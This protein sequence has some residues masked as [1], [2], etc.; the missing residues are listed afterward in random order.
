[1][2]YSSM[3]CLIL[4]TCFSRVVCSFEGSKLALPSICREW[5]V[6]CN[7]LPTAFRLEVSSGCIFEILLPV[8]ADYHNL[9]SGIHILWTGLLCCLG[10]EYDLYCGQYGNI[11]VVLPQLKCFKRILGCLPVLVD[12]GASS[13][14]DTTYPKYSC[15][16]LRWDHLHQWVQ[17]KVAGRFVSVNMYNYMT[18]HSLPSESDFSVLSDQ[19]NSSW[20][21]GPGEPFASLSSGERLNVE[22]A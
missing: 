2:T 3:I 16:C 20:C 13:S 8:F 6:R 14:A 15:R 18:V 7:S 9:D 12:A 17:D 10:F 11:L 19:R 4:F 21:S 5:F 1:M 22:W